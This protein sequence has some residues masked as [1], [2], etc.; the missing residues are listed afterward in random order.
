MLSTTLG[1]LLG[2]RACWERYKHLE[3]ALGGVDAYGRDAAIPLSRV[4]EVNGLSDCLFALRTTPQEQH[5]ERE[6]TARLFAVWCARAT[7]IA[8]GRLLWDL[9]SDPRSRASVEVGARYARGEATD[10][11]L[12]AAWGAASIVSR[13]M[14]TTTAAGLASMAAVA[15]AKPAAWDAAKSAWDAAMAAALVVI[16]DPGSAT[17]VSTANGLRG[18]A[19]GVLA[20]FLLARKEG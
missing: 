11:E 14:A 4:L 3:R 13:T 18:V 16:G 19:G 20:H 8:D 9:L 17:W 2:A 10:E 15:A 12:N 5:S 6:R 7:P 1:R